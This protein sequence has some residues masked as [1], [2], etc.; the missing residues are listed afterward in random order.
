MRSA[1]SSCIGVWGRAT[2]EIDLVHFSLKIMTSGGNNF[3]DFPENRLNKILAVYTVKV[4]V[5]YCGDMSPCPMGLTPLTMSVI[6]LLQIAMHM[7]AEL[8]QIN[9][10]YD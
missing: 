3:N 1:V 9:T 8:V 5:K 4:D 10:C 6:I 2:A 7:V